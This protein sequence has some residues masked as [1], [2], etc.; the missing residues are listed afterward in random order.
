MQV[1]NEGSS[2]ARSSGGSNGSIGS[3]PFNTDFSSPSGLN[4]NISENDSKF[5]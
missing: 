3:V 1:S 2:S 5:I 4:R